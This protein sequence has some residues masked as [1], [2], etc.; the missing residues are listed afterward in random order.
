MNKLRF[1]SKFLLVYFYCI[2]PNISQA[3]DIEHAP[4]EQK[5]QVFTKIYDQFCS[6]INEHYY[7]ASFGGVNWKATCIEGHKKAAAATNLIKLGA[8]MQEDADKLGSS[9]NKIL[10]AKIPDANNDPIFLDTMAQVATQKINRLAKPPE[11]KPVKGASIYAKPMIDGNVFIIGN[12]ING[13]DAYNLGIRPGHVLL[14]NDK[15]NDKENKVSFY[16]GKLIPLTLSE[17][18]KDF[19]TKIHAQQEPHDYKALFGKDAIPIKLEIKNNIQNE[20]IL[21][22]D[23]GNGIKYIRFDNFVIDKL[24]SKIMSSV[25]KDDAKLI[26]D[27]RNNVGGKGNNLNELLSYFVRDDTVLYENACRKDAKYVK[28][29]HTDFKYN[30]KLIILIGPRTSSAAEMFAAVL[31]KQKQAIVMGSRSSGLVLNSIKLQLEPYYT[32]SIP[33]CEVKIVGYG[34]LEGNGVLPDVTFENH[35][36]DEKDFDKDTVLEAAISKF[37]EK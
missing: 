10:P 6:N 18:P 12:V 22:S 23:K 35:V 33:V 14:L 30:N 4:L 34:R 9:H 21:V 15:H 36:I 1:L 19:L 25:N 13:S 2:S 24:A 3:Q 7:D 32:Q 11:Y 29:R 20:E 16:S 37:N 31:Q 17:L 5:S 8:L 28:A 27:L 26:I